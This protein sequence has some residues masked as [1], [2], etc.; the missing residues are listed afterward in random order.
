MDMKIKAEI[1]SEPDEDDY[2]FLDDESAYDVKLHPDG[3]MKEEDCDC[4]EHE[5]DEHRLTGTDSENTGEEKN[6]VRRNP[7][8]EKDKRPEQCTPE[9]SFR[10]SVP[11][12][13]V[14]DRLQLEL[15]VSF[16]FNI[17]VLRQKAG[18]LWRQKME[19]PAL[20]TQIIIKTEPIEPGEGD[21][22]R[23]P[24]TD[25][26]GYISDA[27]M[28]PGP[29]KKDEDDRTLSVPSSPR[30]YE[31][32]ADTN[33]EGEGAKQKWLAMSAVDRI[34]LKKK[35]A[36]NFSPPEKALFLTLFKKYQN[37]LEN[38]K[39]D[40]ATKEEKAAVWRQL[41]KEYN[42]ATREHL[43]STENLKSLWDNFKKAARKAKSGEEQSIFTIGGL[44]ET[45]GP[46]KE[47]EDVLTI[48]GSSGKGL[49]DSC[50]GESKHSPVYYDGVD[51]VIDDD[52]S[53]HSNVE[54]GQKSWKASNS[55]KLL[56]TPK[57]SL[58]RGATKKENSFDDAR[59]ELAISTKE[60]LAA[61]GKRKAELHDLTVKKIKLEILKLKKDMGVIGEKEIRDICEKEGL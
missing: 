36:P 19:T 47:E 30:N 43:R 27:D 57:S 46:S 31:D 38:K 29:Y 14:Y 10:D 41:T 49:A 22:D 39:S 34:L 56:P 50:G 54:N 42:K 12:K 7:K 60:E 17:I 51:V 37:I 53:R 23:M 45:L 33:S 20:G 26:P 3:S 21:T 4:P 2:M 1:K 44:R 15:F 6:K 5:E 25:V 40:T 13:E 55:T 61:D 28:Y 18:L 11:C 59:T 8:C 24:D 9:C 52:D 32:C 58:L 16:P 48:L 35:R